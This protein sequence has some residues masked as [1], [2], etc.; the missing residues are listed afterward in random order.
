MLTRFVACIWPDLNPLMDSSLSDHL[1]QLDY[2]ADIRD[3]GM[4]HKAMILGDPTD[5]NP[6]YCCWKYLQ[7]MDWVH[8]R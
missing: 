5:K 4:S 7:G 3:Q 8:I 2:T 6:K 1:K